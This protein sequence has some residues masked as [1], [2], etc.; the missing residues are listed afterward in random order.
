MLAERN[1]DL[2]D[3]F[4]SL[5]HQASVELSRIVDDTSLST[6]T[7]T[8]NIIRDNIPYPLTDT[9]EQA[10]AINDIVILMFIGFS[11]R[12]TKIANMVILTHLA[13]SANA[14]AKTEILSVAVIRKMISEVYSVQDL[15]FSDILV[16]LAKIEADNVISRDGL[17][18]ARALYYPHT[19]DVV[20]GSTVMFDRYPESTSSY[21]TLSNRLG[22][23]SMN[24]D[25]SVALGFDS[26][27]VIPAY[28]GRSLP[29]QSTSREA[30]EIY[31]KLFS[32]TYHK[33]FS[34]LEFSSDIVNNLISS[35]T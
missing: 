4:N 29:N 11:E 35:S 27:V 31:N 2:V 14:I 24:A 26:S 6:Y 15:W 22:M 1:L 8:L 34:E 18:A 3:K 21:R 33:P 28:V 23:L 30:I 5:E 10:N 25:R 17:E 16:T 13:I 9:L 32:K 20:D 7:E 12:Y 19:P